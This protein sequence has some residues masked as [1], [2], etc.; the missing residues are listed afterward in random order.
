VL[1]GGRVFPGVHHHARF[2]VE[3]SDEE[4][5][6]SVASDDGAMSLSVRGRVSDTLPRGSVFRTVDEASQFFEAGSIGYS[7]TD[8]PGRYDG[9]ELQC[10]S[11]SVIP[12]AV[13]QMESSFFDDRERFPAGSVQFDCALLMRG[14][15]HAWQ[16]RAALCCAAG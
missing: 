2:S 4:L 3:E 8:R 7:V 1:I 6:I 15:A 5:S 11:W 12:L 14:V 10:R 16:P 13:S 9:L